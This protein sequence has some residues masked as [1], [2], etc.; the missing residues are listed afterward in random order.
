VVSRVVPDGPKNRQRSAELEGWNARTTG[1]FPHCHV[2][3]SVSQ[4]SRESF[5]GHV[6][7]QFDQRRNDHI[8]DHATVHQNVA[9]VAVS[10]IRRLEA[11]RE[12]CRSRTSLFAL[13]HLSGSPVASAVTHDERMNAQKKFSFAPR[14]C[15]R[16]RGGSRWPIAW[17]YR[18]RGKSESNTHGH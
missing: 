14:L 10:K 6:Y 5:T 8:P 11:R 1:T 17:P 13:R 4:A 7:W 15:E 2:R 3:N 16:Y 9:L 12:C 18:P